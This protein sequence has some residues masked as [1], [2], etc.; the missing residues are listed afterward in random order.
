MA[1]H[2][3]TGPTGG[4]AFLPSAPFEEL[5]RDRGG[6]HRVSPPHGIHGSSA[7]VYVR[8]KP[9]LAAPIWG[10]P[11]RRENPSYLQI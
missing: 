9:R 10:V 11:D 5:L 3:A 2:N 8:A 7:R 4:K 1:V 6:R